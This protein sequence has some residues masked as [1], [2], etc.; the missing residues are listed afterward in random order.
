MKI[1][2]GKEGQL[3]DPESFLLKA[4]C[5]SLFLCPQP[6]L[7]AKP[8]RTETRG[9]SQPSLPW[10]MGWPR[11]TSFPHPVWKS[12]V[13][14]FFL[15]TE[16]YSWSILLLTCCMSLDNSLPSLQLSLFIYKIMSIPFWVYLLLLFIIDYFL[17]SKHCAN[18]TFSALLCLILI[19]SPWGK[20]YKSYLKN[21]L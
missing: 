20:F 16:S 11:G 10:R 1:K 13:K 21:F 14:F 19:K 6:S 5:F 9:R 17:C 15:D 2:W 12:P 18:V 7:P 4:A 8:D 3:W